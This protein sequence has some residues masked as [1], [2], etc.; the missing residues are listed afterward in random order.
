MGDEEP[1]D[2]LEWVEEVSVSAGRKMQLER[3]EPINEQVTYQLEFPDG[4]TVEEK[5]ELIE[6]AQADARDRCERAL[7]RR[8]EENVRADD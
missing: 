3:Y 7:I 1:A 2:V 6:E 5:A 4:Q 8:Y